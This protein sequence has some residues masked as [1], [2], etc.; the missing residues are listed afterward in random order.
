MKVYKGGLRFK[1]VVYMGK[2]EGRRGD[3]RYVKC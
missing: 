2:H 1:G 3:E